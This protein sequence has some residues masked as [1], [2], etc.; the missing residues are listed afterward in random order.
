MRGFE[1]LPFLS[2]ADV[3]LGIVGWGGNGQV[4]PVFTLLD[5]QF[6]EVP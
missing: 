5:L 3:Y 4:G 2:E 1:T 6:R